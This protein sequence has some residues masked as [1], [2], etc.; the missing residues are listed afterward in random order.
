MLIDPQR[1]LIYDNFRRI[2][3]PPP[4]TDI[5]NEEFAK[6][7]FH[8]TSSDDDA[9]E[10]DNEDSEGDI[11]A[12]Y[13]SPNKQITQ[14][15]CQI[16]PHI[17]EFFRDVDSTSNTLLL[18]KIEQTNN[19]IRKVTKRNKKSVPAMY[20]VP[21]GKLI[22]LQYAQRSILMGFETQQSNIEKVQREIVGL[23]D[24]FTR[25]CQRGLYHWPTCWVQHLM[26]PLHR[27]LEILGVPRDQ[28]MP[29]GNKRDS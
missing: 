5:F 23:R 18:S 1:R 29:P 4:T 9:L 22:M 7:A 21:R 6:G 8:N 20:E 26:G 28:Q 27:K 3:P 10:P 14:L 24:Y 15:H 11:E 13:P 25:T 19:Q 17:E 12:S 2:N 16:T